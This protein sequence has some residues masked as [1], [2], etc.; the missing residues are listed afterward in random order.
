MCTRS[1]CLCFNSRML[2]R[3]LYV[4]LCR[5]CADQQRSALARRSQAEVHL[6]TG[7]KLKCAGVICSAIN[8][9]HGDRPAPTNNRTPVQNTPNRPPNKP[10]V[11]PPIR[12]PNRPPPGE[13]SSF[14]SRRAA[15]FGG[16]AVHSAA[17][18]RP[19]AW[20]SKCSGQGLLRLQALLGCEHSIASA[21]RLRS[22]L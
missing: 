4:K 5:G 16:L 13:S 18:L 2:I 3:L 15:A 8:T 1:S 6:H 20:A 21:V 17:A 22:A 19:C 9:M 7:R 11:G 12:P 10:P 14:C